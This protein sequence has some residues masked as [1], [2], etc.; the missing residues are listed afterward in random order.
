MLE[1]IRFEG[2]NVIVEDKRIIVKIAR[3]SSYRD[4]DADFMERVEKK[5]DGWKYANIYTNCPCGFPIFNN[6]CYIFAEDK[7]IE[8][9]VL[10][11]IIQSL[12]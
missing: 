8:E 10:H 11:N 1:G 9:D 2:E 4:L 7:S 5:Q 6:D 3:W 12:W